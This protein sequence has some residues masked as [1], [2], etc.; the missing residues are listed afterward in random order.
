MADQPDVKDGVMIALYP[1][2]TDTARYVLIDGTPADE[3]HVTM[4]YLGHTDE[5]DADAVKRAVGALAP[6]PA[7]TA[8]VSGH[9]RFTGDEQDVIVA[10]IDAPEIEQLR[11]DLIDVLAIEDIGNASD[12]GYTPHMTLMYVNPDD[13]A[14]F[15]RLDTDPIGFDTVW[16]VYGEERTAFP[17]SDDT[18]ESIRPYART[19]YAQGWAASGGPMTDEVRA[20]CIA[21][22]DLCVEHAHEPDVLEVALHL[23]HLEGV[24]AQVFARREALY[25]AHIHAVLK[26][27]RAALDGV[28]VAGAVQIFRQQVGLSEAVDREALRR[29]KEAA[30]NA[31]VRLLQ[32][33][34][35]KAAWQGLRDAMRAVVTSGRAEGYA[36]A[37]AVAA[38]KQQMI[39]FDFDIAFQ[40]AYDAMENL[41]DAWAAADPWL[42]RMVGRAADEFGRTL[43]DLASQGADYEQM[44][45]AG[46][47]VLQD[48]TADRD[49]VGFIVDWAASTG[50]SR[51]ALDL[52]AS[53]GVQ[54]V[55]WLTAG[56]GRVCPVCETNGQE[57]PFLITDFP[58]MPAHPLCRCVASAEFTLSPDYGGFF[59]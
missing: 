19:A 50:M 47:D 52:Y 58:T 33:V 3:M 7:F 49:I 13:P 1:S 48:T 31:A 29:M 59:T 56:D 8:N 2:A 11:R 35:G 32:W 37:L 36:S 30:R 9:A 39:G 25:R 20:G 6:R 46:L 22:M 54:Q 45:A 57:S 16:V 43:G 28:D 23:G 44:V 40:H 18:A 24:W 5:V 4:V 21:V 38:S 14:P 15:R 10:L 12:H 55:S 41:G 51:G 42:E 53:E 17:L 27:W 34:P 26:A